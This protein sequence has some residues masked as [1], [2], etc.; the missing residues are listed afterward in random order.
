[1]RLPWKR[2]D[3]LSLEDKSTEETVYQELLKRDYDVFSLRKLPIDDPYF[4]DAS[5]RLLKGLEKRPWISIISNSME[6]LG[7]LSRAFP[8]IYAINNLGKS[9][10]TISGDEIID[11]MA[12][13]KTERDISLK[14]IE[15]H[16]LLYIHRFLSKGK[17]LRSFEM[18]LDSLLSS[19]AS[20]RLIIDIHCNTPNTDSAMRQALTYIEDTAG[21][22][23]AATLAQ[24]MATL[25][26]YVKKEGGWAT[27]I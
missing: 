4:I 25:H 11:V 24:D 5:K 13:N 22:H 26:V 6:L 20:K 2:D 7:D 19:R 12:E 27:K 9:V 21:K 10:I 14:V 1:M 8:V 3:T 18:G 23:V 17:L 16:H 15:K